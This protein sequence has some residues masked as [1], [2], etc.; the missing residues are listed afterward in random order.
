MP[1]SWGGF[2]GQCRHIFHTWSVWD[3]YVP[4]TSSWANVDGMVS[5]KD[6]KE[7]LY[8]EGPNSTSRRVAGGVIDAF[9]H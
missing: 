1:I 3:R 5:R 4:A 9:I 2:G 7:N 6:R 8:K